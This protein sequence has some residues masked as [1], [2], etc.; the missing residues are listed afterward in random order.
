MADHETTLP[1]GGHH[2][3]HLAHHFDSME[4]QFDSS[5]LGMW[6]FLAT[7]VLLFGGL[8]C[9]YT[10]YRALHPE[11]FDWGHH[12]LD[13]KLGGLNTLV[14]ITSSL[15]MALAVRCA[16]LGQRRRLVAFLSLTLVGAAAFLVVKYFEYK[17]KVEHRLLWGTGFD[18]DPAYV[19]AHFGGE[20]GIG[21]GGA[22]GPGGGH[23]ATAAAP[24]A[25]EAKPKGDAAQGKKIARETCASCHGMDMRGMP[26]NG[27]NLV[28]SEFVASRSDEEM[29]QYLVVGRQPFDPA[30]TTGVAMPPR[31]GNPLLT[32][33][34]L[35]DVVAYLREIQAT[36]KA[37][38]AP[39]ADAGDA[40]APADAPDVPAAEAAA[41]ETDLPSV[42]GWVLP[43]PPW[44][45]GGLSAAGLAAPSELRQQP[46]VNAHH[47]FGI[48]FLMTGLHGIHVVAGM[49]AIGWLLFRSIRGDFGAGYFGPVDL[50]G[51]YWHL[52]D[53]I[54]IFLF[55]LLYLVT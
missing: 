49:V 50:G 31:G 29:V 20:A 22:G 15:T 55:P 54:W 46:P 32:N 5:K 42:P 25:A 4:Q 27:L 52:V 43:L 34:R 21:R 19:A 41:A 17:P 14:L 38:P 16:Q 11:I 30:N 9:A 18:P 12:F 13:K 36:E 10:L 47:F 44:G 3:A 35:L 1:A 51:L 48:Y 24:A 26:R 37:N 6:I 23:D 39:V 33:E 40:A 28:T 2:D 45:P 53:L 7:E 8:F